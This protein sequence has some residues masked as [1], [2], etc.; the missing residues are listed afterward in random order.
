MN[1]CGK[2]EVSKCVVSPL[3]LELMLAKSQDFL[4]KCTCT[5]EGLQTSRLNLG[6]GP[7]FFTFPQRKRLGENTNED[8]VKIHKNEE[9]R[10]N[11]FQF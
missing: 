10:R 2:Y 3:L 11:W 4:K 6:T 8:F 1:V 5:E 7:D 9:R